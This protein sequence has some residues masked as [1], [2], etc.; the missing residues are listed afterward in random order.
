MSSAHAL[1]DRHGRTGP[2]Q[3]APPPLPALTVPRD[4]R[5]AYTRRRCAGTADRRRARA[6]YSV[7]AAAT[8]ATLRSGDAGARVPALTANASNP[9]RTALP[10]SLPAQSLLRPAARDGIDVVIK[11]ILLVGLPPLLRQRARLL[12][13]CA[14]VRASACAMGRARAPLHRPVAQRAEKNSNQ[15]EYSQGHGQPNQHARDDLLVVRRALQQLQPS[16]AVLDAV[17]CV[18]WRRAIGSAS[19]WRRALR[20]APADG[21]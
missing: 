12:A 2:A 16:G 4:D 17:H 20:P 18:P 10:V 8:G 14:N 21:N 3:A 11:H 19:R 1:P 13:A 15:P 7:P 5:R 9:R 6:V